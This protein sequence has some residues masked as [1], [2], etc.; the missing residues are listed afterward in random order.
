V[1]LLLKFLILDF[2]RPDEFPLEENIENFIIV[3][4]VFKM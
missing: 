2:G 4:Y 3:L 1:V